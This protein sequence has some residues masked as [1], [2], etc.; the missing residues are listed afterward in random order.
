MIKAIGFDLWETLI[1]D[2]P[3]ASRAQAELRVRGMESILAARGYRLEA[4]AIEAAYRTCWERCQELYWSADRD[5]PCRTQIDHFLEDAGVDTSA[6][7][8]DVLAELERVY[9]YAALEVLPSPVEGAVELLAALK[10]KGLRTGVISNTGRTPGYVLRDVL[11]KLGLSPHID[12]AVFSNEHG[13]C[14]PQASIFEALR[15]Q[16]GVAFDEML[17][18]GDN[19]YVDV[20][21]AQRCG[22]RGIHFDPPVRGTAIAPPVE[23][24]LRIIPDWRV[25]KLADIEGVLSAE[26]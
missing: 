26:C 4:A 10:R 23:H 7:G 24:G 22:I 17:F 6:L 14:K 11:V 19:P 5:I 2:T 16:M 8:E 21:G 20:W 3:A 15:S 1:T 13:E 12:A 9:A 25:T 18:V